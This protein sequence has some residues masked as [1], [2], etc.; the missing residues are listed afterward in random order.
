MGSSVAKHRVVHVQRRQMRLQ[1][2]R[3]LAQL[4]QPAR[5]ERERQRVRD[6]ELDHVLPR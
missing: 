3:V 2:A 1:P 5:E 4:H 6:R